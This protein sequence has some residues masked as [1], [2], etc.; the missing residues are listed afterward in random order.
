VNTRDLLLSPKRIDTRIALI[1]QFASRA[2][3]GERIDE[4]LARDAETGSG[5]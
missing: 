4:V 1:P 3:P 2:S 5:R